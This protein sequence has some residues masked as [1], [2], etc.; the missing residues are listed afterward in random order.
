[1]KKTNR[2]IFLIG[3]LVALCMSLVFCFACNESKTEAEVSLS[4][5]RAEAT[6]IFGDELTL[7]PTYGGAEGEKL[8]WSTS[9][10]KIV[11]VND[12]KVTATGCGEAEISV[13][14]GGKTAKCTVQVSFG[15]IRPE[16]V[17]EGLPEKVRIGKGNSIA[18]KAAVVFNG[19]KFACDYT[20]EV[21]D[22]SI[23]DYSEGKLL[24]KEMGNTEVT[25]KSD[26]N[27]FGGVLMQKKITVEVFN[28]VI[29]NAFVTINGETY[30]SGVAELAVTEEWQ[31][32]KY[33]T[34]S[35]I[36]FVVS[37]N[38]EE[39]NL[40]GEL[41][42]GQDVVSCD[43]NVLTALKEGSAVYSANYKDSLG[44][45]YTC[46][47]NVSV[48]CPVADYS[49]KIELCTDEAFPIEKYFGAGAEI[50]SAE[51]EGKALE[52]D[53][54]SI[55][56]IARGT[57]TAA[58]TVKTNKGGYRF[59]NVYAYTRKI[60]KSNFISTFSLGNNKVIDGYY[61]L[62][63]DIDGLA[64]FSQHTGNANTYFKGTFDGE[65]HTVK[66]TANAN[67]LFGALNEG[68]T[69][70]N[71]KFVFTFPN[72]TEACGLA[73]NQGTFN[74]KK[75]VYLNNVYVT[76]EN[77]TE[78]ACALMDNMPDALEMT[79]V[80]VKING[81]AALGKYT[82]VDS[83]RTALFRVDQA[84]NDGVTGAYAGKFINI[85]VITE[86][87]IPMSNGKRW[88]GQIYTSYAWNDEDK[89]G[90]FR[91]EN[92]KGSFMYHRLFNE[93]AEGSAESKLFGVNTYSYGAKESVKNGGI[94]RYDTAAELIAAGVTEVGS[95]TV[96]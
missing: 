94:F 36:K 74:N 21:A 77:Y 71:V 54:N 37:D 52:V 6:M 16:L 28:D 87:F 61:V 68:A 30:A 93:N 10:E 17:I 7:V 91:R 44:N 76:T 65:G 55:A 50:L 89:L 8:V 38:G 85:K 75:P 59:D 73:K 3:L 70:K 56:F 11:S 63:E 5:D 53:G 83:C 80:L 41:V 47:V 27:S 25:V 24:G 90:D 13:S 39:K 34:S 67:G 64:A 46:S 51:S 23:T 92:G 2:S 31:G 42:S 32:I 45:E 9:D 95:W 18:I 49:E 62:E 78:Q 33:G 15:D 79:D 48:I 19:K 66:A 43:G 96:E 86:S 35:E 26:W 40:T 4:L 82:E 14:Y 12:G 57:D 22:K 69:I 58:L 72:G 88:N 60:N 1:M 29:I 84:Y 20:V 81:N